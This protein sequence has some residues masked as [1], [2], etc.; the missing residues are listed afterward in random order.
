MQATIKCESPCYELERIIL[1]VQNPFS[2][3][4]DFRIVL[5]E[6]KGNMMLNS[7]TGSTELIKPKRKKAKKIRS[8]TDHG[9]A[10]PET[11]PSPEEEEP[12][13]TTLKDTDKE[14]GKCNCYTASR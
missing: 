8:R 10:R 14:N 9:Q 6:A 7:T 12:V 4:G 1:D 5:V 13:K 11:P 3:G 2:E